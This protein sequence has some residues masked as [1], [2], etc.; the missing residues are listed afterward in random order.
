MRYDR[1]EE[2]TER[3]SAR[4]RGYNLTTTD[5]LLNALH[6]AGLTLTET[7]SG[8]SW[9]VDDLHGKAT[10][11]INAVSDAIYHVRQARTRRRGAA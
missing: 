8:Y 5:T 10:N 7:T 2:L 6:V 3:P 4:R 1:Q 9:A 11:A